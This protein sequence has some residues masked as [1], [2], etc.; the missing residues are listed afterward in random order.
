MLRKGSPDPSGKYILYFMEASQR[1]TQNF[2]LELALFLSNQY[3]KPL[4]VFFGLTDKYRFSNIRYYKFMLEGLCEL[5]KTLKERGIKLVIQ[6]VDPPEGVI[7]LSKK[8]SL[9]VTDKGYLK[10][11]RIWRKKITAAIT[12]PFLEVEGD[13]VCPVE[14]LSKKLIPYARILKP[15]LLKVLPFFLEE[16]PQFEPKV[17]SVNFDIDSW[18]EETVEAY[19]EKLQI[20]KSIKPVSYFKGGE[21]EANLRLERFIRER[22]HLYARYRSDPG[23]EATSEL[24][25]YLR[26]GQ[27]SPLQILKRVFKEV[28]LEEENVRALVNELVIWREL[29][30]N[31][32]W[33]N[34]LYNQYEGLPF[35]ARKTFEEHLS[36]K[37]EV[38]YDLEILE[39]AQTHDPYWNAAQRELLERGKIHNYV[40]MYWCKRLLAWTKHPKEAFDI[41]CYLNDKYALDGRDPNGYAGISWCLGAFDRPFY[42]RP[43]YGKVRFMSKKALERKIHFKKY[44]F[45]FG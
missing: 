12:I 14:T 43:V 19:L 30:R 39:Q 38:F 36:D 6:K 35:W 42:E 9:I 29:A 1:A 34:P 33:F 44:L 10:H 18:E 15:R 13:V 28:P 21:K 3:Q 23:V 27:I 31:Y 40:R 20:D 8:A 16:I 45:Q 37:R 41:A 17:K 2:A 4:I 5:K 26:F 22:L 24:S 32:A 11:Q 25:P 7:R